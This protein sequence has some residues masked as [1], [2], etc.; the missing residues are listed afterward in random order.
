MNDH[1]IVY[2]ISHTKN[3]MVQFINRRLREEGID[4]LSA[5]HGNILNVLY[6]TKEP[7]T[8]S[9]IARLIARDKSTVT[10]LAGRL[11]RLGYIRK[12][13]SDKDRR[14]SYIALTEK[15]KALAPIFARISDDIYQRA[16]KD[17]SEED[18]A[19][20]LTLLKKIHSHF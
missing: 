1:F 14:I 19:Q 15:G 4:D 18:K 5:P 12:V 16:W 17:F 9:D 20:F 2:L 6:R 13:R 11:I 3:R 10:A 8:M 7:L